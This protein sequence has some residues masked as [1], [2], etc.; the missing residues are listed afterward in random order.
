MIGSRI[1]S[2]K[3]RRTSTGAFAVFFSLLAAV[4][5]RASMAK[6][7]AED[8]LQSQG[9]R[10]KVIPFLYEDVL[11]MVLP[12]CDP[13]RD[14]LSVLLVCRLWRTVGERVLDPSVR[15]NRALTRS[16]EFGHVDAVRSLL[17]DERVDPRAEDSKPLRYACKNGR[18]RVVR[19][20]LKDE[21]ADPTARRYETAMW[22]IGR[23]YA[24]VLSSLDKDPRVDLQVCMDEAMYLAGDAQRANSREAGRYLKIEDI[25]LGGGRSPYH[26]RILCESGRERFLRVKH[27]REPS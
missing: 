18:V 6:R 21:R 20:L 15:N 22:A 4:A 17:K 10:R 11:S 26:P 27:E 13:L 12:F 25:I 7:G 16:C 23:G 2:G 8:D 3:S 1:F 19:M 14:R 24:N 5:P 9:K